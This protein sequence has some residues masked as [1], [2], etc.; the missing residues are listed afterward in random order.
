MQ[1]VILA[2]GKGTHLS[3]L[4]SNMPKPMVS[5]FDKP[6]VEHIVELLKR[7]KI[8]DIV[9][10]LAYK[11]EPVIDYF[12]DGSRWGVDIQY[13][14]EDVPKGTAGGLRAIQPALNS[15]F[16]VIPGDAVT[17]L[18]LTSALR[19]HRKRSAIATMLCYEA[20]DPSQLAIVDTAAD[21]RIT[22]FFGQPGRR[23]TFTNKVNT[24]IYILEPEALSSIP[25]DARYDLGRDL[26]PRLLQ[27]QEP[28][29]ACRTEGYWSD[30]GNLAQYRNVHFDAL[31]NKVEL[32]LTG[33]QITD[34]VWL[35]Q[36]VKIHD[37]VKLTSPVYVGKG[38]R[39]E[40]EATLGRFAVIGD[41]SLIGPKASITHSVLGARTAVG[42]NAQVY[43]CVIG[44]GFKLCSE[45]HINDEIVIR[46]ASDM[47]ARAGIDSQYLSPATS[48]ARAISWS[49]L[50][51][52]RLASR[53][54][55][56]QLAL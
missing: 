49:G 37:S 26:F 56:Q 29:Y 11:P 13:S 27:N 12:G 1:A 55:A 31:M 9:I 30:I 32:S 5:L 23:E 25:Y 4:T 54:S 15:T 21:G 22:R 10:T 43:G 16:L 51:L 2:G 7:H 45:H 20:H 28:V 44:T 47:E 50:E 35:G 42:S 41:M 24:G 46:D 40:A 36:N 17:D 8:H 33:S 18:D 52:A 53:E 3:P 39:I 48:V 6:A 34:G 19:F 14:L 38:T